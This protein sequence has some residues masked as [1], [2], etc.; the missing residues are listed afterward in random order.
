MIRIYLTGLAF[1]A[2]HPN[3]TIEKLPDKYMKV[4]MEEFMPGV[5]SH[6]PSEDT[7]FDEFIDP[8]ALFESIKPSGK[9]PAID[10]PSEIIPKLR[11][12]QLRAAYWM[13]TK[14]TRH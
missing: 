1:P 8:Q 5:I 10:Q 14:F 7:Q 6:L 11:P 2:C 13:S 12:Y 9:E 4:L 3:E